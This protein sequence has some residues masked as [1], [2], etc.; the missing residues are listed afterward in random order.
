MATQA[1][2]RHAIHC[3]TEG[4]NRQGGG[5]VA[6]HGTAAALGHVV[7]RQHALVVATTLR[8]EQRTLWGIAQD[9]L[10]TTLAA[11]TSVAVCR[12]QVNVM[13]ARLDATAT[14]PALPHFC[15]R[16]HSIADAQ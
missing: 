7:L 8:P 1:G 14:V 5:R 9:A 6:L 15:S 16:A 11:P 2:L 13:V 12:E 10:L 4:G 3:Q